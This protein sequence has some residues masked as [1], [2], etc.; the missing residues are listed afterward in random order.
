ML[1][2]LLIICFSIGAIAVRAQ[3]L[4]PEV[5]ASDGGYSTAAGV[6]LSWTLGET[7]SETY[8]AGPN[9]LTQGFQQP[10][11]LITGIEDN[12]AGVSVAVYPNPSAGQLSVKFVSA[13]E[14]KVKM[15]LFDMNGKL[16]HEQEASVAAGEQVF[17][18]N[19]TSLAI[20][21][22]TLRITDTE[23]K[24]QSTYKLQKN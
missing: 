14:R 23:K 17:Y 11:I 6:S 3:T 12:N 7:I 8:T 19:I 16:V 24:T 4:T 1:K 22:Y 2:R 10:E 21:Q 9:T 18:M 20:G 15:Q 13:E 5:L